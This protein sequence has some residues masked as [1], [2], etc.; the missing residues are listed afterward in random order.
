MVS[1]SGRIRSIRPLLFFLLNAPNPADTMYLTCPSIH[2]FDE[3]SMRWKSAY[4]ILLIGLVAASGSLAS[5]HLARH[6]DT[7]SSNCPACIVAN[8]GGHALPAVVPTVAPPQPLTTVPATP[9]IT[10]SP[11]PVVLQDTERGPPRLA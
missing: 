9:S 8:Q 3:R 4:A 6:H 11:H 1:W 7:D 2:R 10:T 5:L